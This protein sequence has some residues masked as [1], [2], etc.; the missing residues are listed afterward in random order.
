MIYD[1]FDEVEI[2]TDFNKESFIALYEKELQDMTEE[3][4][5]ELEIIKQMPDD[6][7][8]G[9]V[10]QRL[11][12]NIF[13]ILG[14]SLAITFFKNIFLH[15]FFRPTRNFRNLAGNNMKQTQK[16]KIT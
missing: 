1:Y 13:I 15:L 7:F 5:E 8:E 4:K 2:G 12:I 16:N 14:I 3:D 9:Y 11:Y 10:R 6:E